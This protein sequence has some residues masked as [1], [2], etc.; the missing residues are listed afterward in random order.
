[1]RSCEKLNSLLLDSLTKKNHRSELVVGS[2]TFDWFRRFL[3]S[4]QDLLMAGV[5]QSSGRD[6]AWS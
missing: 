2:T 5:H 1:M 3:A 6:T 4:Y